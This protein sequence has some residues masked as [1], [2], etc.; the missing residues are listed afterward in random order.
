MRALVHHCAPKPTPC[1]PVAT[2]L[3]DDDSLAGTELDEMDVEDELQGRR[4]CICRAKLAEINRRLKAALKRASECKVDACK[5]AARQA[6]GALRKAKAALISRCQKGDAE[7]CQPGAA[8]EDEDLE[9]EEL[10]QLDEDAEL[11]GRK[12]CICRRKLFQLNAKLRQATAS[13]KQCKKEACKKEAREFIAKLV[14]A[15]KALLKR[16]AA[17]RTCD[18]DPSL[19]IIEDEELAGD[20]IDGMDEQSELDGRKACRCRAIAAEIARRTAVLNKRL[21]E[22]KVPACKAAVKKAL[23]RLSKARA[24]LAKRCSAEDESF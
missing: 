5:E 14:A 16:C 6:I 15:K 18:A 23:E 22:C 1:K 12:A 8:D 24:A 10:E 4:E 21:N 20:D 2:E 19:E 17:R 11:D 3:L 9:G 7:P 13:A